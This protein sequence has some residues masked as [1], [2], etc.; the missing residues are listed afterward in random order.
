MVDSQFYGPYAAVLRV[1]GSY[2]GTGSVSMA[3]VWSDGAVQGLRCENVAIGG[4]VLGPI[5]YAG[6]TMPAPVCGALVP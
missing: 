6:N 3:R 5:W 2:G 4:G 1:S